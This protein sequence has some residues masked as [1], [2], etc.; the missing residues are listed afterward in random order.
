M[1]H[2]LRLTIGA[3]AVLALTACS[4]MHSER[5]VIDGVDALC[6]WRTQGFDQVR[7][8]VCYPIGT[9]P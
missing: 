4:E 6:T 7:E 3:C 2:P 5:R 1:K 9:Q 8:P